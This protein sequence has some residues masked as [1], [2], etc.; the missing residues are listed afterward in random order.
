MEKEHWK[1]MGK[2]YNQQKHWK[3]QKFLP[4]ST[5]FNSSA[6]ASQAFWTTFFSLWDLWLLSYKRNIFLNCHR[7]ESKKC[8]FRVTLSSF[9]HVVTSFLFIFSSYLQNNYFSIQI[10]FFKRESWQQF[11]SALFY[12]TECELNARFEISENVDTFL[13]E[14]RSAK[15]RLVLCA[16]K[17]FGFT[18]SVK[19]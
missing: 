19:T 12:V 8:F 18:L 17:V 3:Q 16:K 11:L 15:E 6:T 9:L 10:F 1:E 4:S 5:Q 13:W 2:I 14:L 7:L